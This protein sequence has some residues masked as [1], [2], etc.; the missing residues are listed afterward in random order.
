MNDSILLIG[1]PHSSKTVFLSQFY[2]RLQKNKSKLSLYKPVEDIS[3][4][5]SAL[6]ALASGD[7]PEATNAELHIK[8][9]LPIQLGEKEIDLLCPDYGGEQV[10]KIILSRELDTHW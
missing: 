7:E 1:K 4:I 10:N 6:N 3:P 5:S 8:F 9:T 2:K